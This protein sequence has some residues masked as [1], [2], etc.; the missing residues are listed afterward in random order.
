MA[1][2]ATPPEYTFCAP[3]LTT[4]VAEATPPVQIFCSPPELMAPPKAM[5]P[6]EIACEPLPDTAMA[7][8]TPPSS[9]FCCPPLFNVADRDT[10]PELTISAPPDRSTVAEASP[11]VPMRTLPPVDTVL[12]IVV[13]PES[14][15]C[16]PPK[17]TVLLSVTPAAPTCCAPADT[18][19]PL[20]VVPTTSPVKSARAGAAASHS[21]SID[22]SKLGKVRGATPKWRHPY[23]R[24]RERGFIGESSLAAKRG[25][26]FERST[27]NRLFKLIKLSL[28]NQTES[29]CTQKSLISDIYDQ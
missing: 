19:S 2:S 29:I 11:P 14:T 16:T 1:R 10:P 5:P 17:S 27:V 12:D 9:T 21:P 6:E 25:G 3:L 7:E 24:R 8:A 28:I 18:C 13:P 4:V 22:S 15:F 20:T 26:A 23:L